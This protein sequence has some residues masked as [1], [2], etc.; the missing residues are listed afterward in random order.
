MAAGYTDAASFSFFLNA[1]LSVK[2]QSAATTVMGLTSVGMSAWFA[3]SG[4]QPVGGRTKRVF[5]ITVALAALLILAPIIVIVAVLIWWHDGG[6]PFYAHQRVGHGGSRFACFKFRSM[7]ANSPQVLAEL[8]ASDVVAAREWAATQKLR[9]DP[10]VTP[11][12]RL[13]RMSSLDELPQL[14][15]VLFGQMSIVGPRPIVFAEVARYGSDY[16][17]YRVC[18]PGLTGVWQISGRSDT[19]YAE[20]VRYDV[21]YTACWSFWRDVLIVLKTVPVVVSRRGSC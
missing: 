19:S 11:I 1:E 20:R 21:R 15:N 18:R 7:V 2:A 12:G 14:F 4:S 3:E 5:D 16:Q 9:S 8:L 6:S 10:R 13:L 17:H